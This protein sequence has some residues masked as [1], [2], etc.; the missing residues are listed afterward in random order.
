MEQ[1]VYFYRFLNVES[2]GCLSTP[3]GN[4]FA[5]TWNFFIICPFI[6]WIGNGI[7]I[8]DNI[9]KNGANVQLVNIRQR[10]FSLTKC[11]ILKIQIYAFYSW[12]KLSDL[13]SVYLNSGLKHQKWRI[14]VNS[15]V[16]DGSESFPVVSDTRLGF[17]LR[18]FRW[19]STNTLKHL[20][21][22]SLLIVEHK[23]TVC[24]NCNNA[25]RPFIFGPSTD[26]GVRLPTISTI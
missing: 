6:S 16:V 25:F 26:S 20:S 24:R 13:E 15:S 7:F 3:S 10:T 17:L 8:S 2:I 5:Q 19:F 4:I 18:L 9:G 11:F 1:N 21:T 23:K 12:S 14:F 22:C